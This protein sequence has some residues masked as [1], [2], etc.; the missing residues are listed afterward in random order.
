MATLPLICNRLSKSV[1]QAW[2][3]D[4][5]CACGELHDLRLW[6]DH[7]LQFG[8]PFGYFP[9]AKK[10]GLLLRSSFWIMYAIFFQST[11][12]LM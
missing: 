8:P 11:P 9:N 6:W 2:Y 5:A 12:A 10:P 3:A 1:V 4:D 7:V